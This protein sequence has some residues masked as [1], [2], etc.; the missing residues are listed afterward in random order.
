MA[1]RI[2]R[3]E[4]IMMRKLTR[5]FILLISFDYLYKSTGQKWFSSKKKN[6]FGL[7][8][9]RIHLSLD[10]VDLMLFI[11]KERKA[12]PWIQ[13]QAGL[14]NRIEIFPLII[15]SQQ[16]FLSQE[17]NSQLCPIEDQARIRKGGS[18]GSKAKGVGQYR[19][20]NETKETALNV[21]VSVSEAT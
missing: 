9:F 17:N 6:S 15:L 7:K 4:K 19:A 16:M 2:N 3:F 12:K 1:T 5:M 18:E 8:M 14:S 11:N 21:V 13:S 20:T 10:Q